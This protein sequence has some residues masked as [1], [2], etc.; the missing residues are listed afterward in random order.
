MLFDNFCTAC[1]TQ[2]DQYG[3]AGNCPEITSERGRV[4][5]RTSRLSPEGAPKSSPSWRTPSRRPSAV[6][7]NKLR[8]DGGIDRRFKTR[9]E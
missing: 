3:H 2:V 9:I 6:V 1:D 4:V 7:V 8:K 5:A